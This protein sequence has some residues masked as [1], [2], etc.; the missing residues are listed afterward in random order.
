VLLF[1][2]LL[3]IPGVFLYLC[4]VVIS[5]QKSNPSEGVQQS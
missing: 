3:L 5:H 1:V 2:T 4:S